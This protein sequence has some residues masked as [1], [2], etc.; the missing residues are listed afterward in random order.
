MGVH[1][2]DELLIVNSK[3]KKDVETVLSAYRSV[4]SDISY[5]SMP[6]TSG[7]RYYNVL[8]EYEVKSISE[9]L[10]KDKDALVKKIIEPNIEEG[11][12]FARSLTGKTKYPVVAPGMF[13]PKKNRWSQEDYMFLWYRVIEQ[14]S[15]QLHFIDGWEYSNGAAQEFVRGIEMQFGFVNPINGME[16]FPSSNREELEKE[17]QRLKKVKLL[18]ND[19]KE[20]RIHHGIHMLSHSIL[21]LEKRGFD[22]KSLSQSLHKLFSVGTYYQTKLDQRPYDFYAPFQIEIFMEG[23]YPRLHELTKD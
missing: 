3:N 16:Y 12:A 7:T 1:G 10:E 13:E 17:Y 15:A 8:E 22:V 21:N 14:K 6:I 23:I 9:L 20:L 18:D 5:A 19:K 11:V 2:T 4:L